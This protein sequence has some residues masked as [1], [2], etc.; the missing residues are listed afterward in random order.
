MTVAATGAVRQSYL[1]LANLPVVDLRKYP[2]GAT[3]LT[4]ALAALPAT[5]GTIIVPPSATRYVIASTVV[6]NKPV[7]F[8]GAGPQS[9]VFEVAGTFQV[10]ASDV[11]FEGIG[12]Y[13]TTTTS[14]VL[15]TKTSGAG[16]Y[17]G[18]KF[19]DCRFERCSVR[20]TKIGR[21]IASGGT[22]TTGTDLASDCKILDSELAGYLQNYTIEIGGQTDTEIRGCHIHDAGLDINAGDGIKVIAGSV[23]T[24]IADNVIEDVQR[25]GIDDYDA[26]RSTIV[27]NTIRRC[28][29][30][31]IDFKWSATDPNIAT[32]GE[33]IIADNR[34]E[35]P[36]GNGIDADVFRCNVVNNVILSAGAI[37]IRASQSFDGSNAD[38]TYVRI[39]GNIVSGCAGGGISFSNGTG[40]TVAQNLCLSNTGNG[41]TVNVNNDHSLLTGNICIGNSSAG[42]SDS[43]TTSI[44][45]DNYTQDTTSKYTVLPNNVKLQSRLAA[46]TVIDLL[47]VTAGG[48]FNVGET[49]NIA[50]LNLLASGNITAF[51]DLNV[52]TVGKGLKVKEGTNAKQGVATLVAGTVTV[53]NTA[54][55][56]SSRI[57]LTGQDNNATGALRVSA[58][59][60]G[61][62]FVITSS[63]AGDT[64]VV[65]YEIFEPGT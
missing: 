12:F 2:A 51:G 43:S 19:K 4:A 58:R 38:T 26:G 11:T 16:N 42:I 48:S 45:R 29:G 32:M 6:I 55:T 54:V 61:T 50:T 25:D 28:G 23:G 64:G 65:A 46:G 31:G 13:G 53:S 27:V 14:H 39:I 37:G 24:I 35:S 62:S 22:D 10:G 7:R 20:F 18:W 34:I 52:T 17:T 44:R 5:G 15:T 30:D 9:S 59:T 3:G 21:T 36:G 1:R 49:T 56:A 33:N 57:Q 8:V 63:N 47:N 60:A 40:F 41:I